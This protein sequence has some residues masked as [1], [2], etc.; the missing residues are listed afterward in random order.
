M[1]PLLSVRWENRNTKNKSAR[2]K[3]LNTIITKS[4]IQFEYK[5][6]NLVLYR[7]VIRMKLGANAIVIWAVNLIMRYGQI[8]TFHLLRSLTKWFLNKLF[9]KFM[10][11]SV[12]KPK[13]ITIFRWMIYQ[14]SLGAFF[15][16]Y[17]LFGSDV[18]FRSATGDSDY[19]S[20][21]FFRCCFQK[22]SVSI[23]ALRYIM[24][25]NFTRP[26]NIRYTALPSLYGSP[27]FIFRNKIWRCINLVAVILVEKSR[28]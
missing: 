12:C 10:V 9:F 2:N 26:V 23:N 18:S 6:K 22:V 28:W 20:F 7:T 27:V 8:T 17:Y 4:R 11:V 3:Y 25:R 24:I 5:K 19:F 13:I 16:R 15:M 14:L 21:F 1:R